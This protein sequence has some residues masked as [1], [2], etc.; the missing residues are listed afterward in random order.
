MYLIL[1]FVLT[2]FKNNH[3]A[4]DFLVFFSQPFQQLIKYLSNLIYYN[5]HFIT[6][7]NQT[8]AATPFHTFPHH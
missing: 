2:R 4:N 5:C 7:L 3:I 1:K 6:I 8:D